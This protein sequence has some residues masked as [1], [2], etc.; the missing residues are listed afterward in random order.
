MRLFCGKN[1]LMEFL[2]FVVQT[3]CIHVCWLG[4]YL[5]KNFR[6]NN[7]GAEMFTFHPVDDFILSIMYEAC[8]MRCLSKSYVAIKFIFSTWKLSIQTSRF[9]QK[10][11][12]L[13]KISDGFFSLM[14]LFENVCVIVYFFWTF[15][16]FYAR[17]L[18]RST[19]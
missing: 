6:A 3:Q 8:I 14:V 5:P 1:I 18:Q 2:E 7:G 9:K 19:L 12:F 17:K 10:Y 11:L 4:D 16:K 13:Q 15:Q